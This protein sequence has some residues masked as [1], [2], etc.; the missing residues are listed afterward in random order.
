MP[1]RNAH[2]ALFALAAIGCGEGGLTLHLELPEDPSL[3]PTEGG[4][5]AEVALVTRAPGGASQRLSRS[6]GTGEGLDLGR[7]EAGELSLAVELRAQGGRLLGYGRTPEPLELAEGDDLDV[8]INVRRPMVYLSGEADELATFDASRDR[9]GAVLSGIGLG[10]AAAASATSAD[11]A[12]IVV[13][14]DSDPGVDLER[15]STSNHQ[16]LGRIAAVPPRV[17]DLAVS[18]DGRFVVAAHRSDTGGADPGGVTIVDTGDPEHPSTVSLGDV[19]RVVLDPDRSAA[20]ALS[21]PAVICP[22]DAP[23]ESQIYEL[24]LANPETPRALGWSGTAADIA[25]DPDTGTLYVADPCRGQVLSLA[26]GDAAPSPVLELP[27]ASAVAVHEGTL[28]AAGNAAGPQAQ[29]AVVRMD[30]SGGEPRVIQLPAL[31]ERAVSLDLE[32]PGQQNEMVASA[33][34]VAVVDLA[35]VP[36]SDRVAL[37]SLAIYQ[38]EA[39]TDGVVELTPDMELTAW[40]Y[41]LVDGGGS[42]IQRVR[43]RCDLQTF[44]DATTILIDWKCGQAPDQ[45]LAPVEFEPRTISVLYGSR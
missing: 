29:L 40:E 7:L 28:I 41:Q 10:G 23:P 4:E 43:T 8:S 12:E 17:G 16:P 18:A 20:F 38:I 2:L 22:T 9:E 35:A 45:E 44:P 5:V 1:R 21:D 13:A 36:G 19:R 42:L 34:A 26:P 25:L 33:D 31:Q 3:S 39:I 14:T 11:G 37:V 27:A 15:I 32:D 6:G 30:L 24:S